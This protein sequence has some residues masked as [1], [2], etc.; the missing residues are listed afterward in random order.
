M[1]SA[2]SWIS[3]LLLCL[4]SGAVAS[5]TNGVLGIN[6][7]C[8]VQTGCFPG[9]APGFPVTI[10]GT[11]GRSYRLTSDL[12]FGG[13]D[14]TGIEIAASHTTI[15]MAGFRIVCSGFIPPST[16]TTCAATGSGTG[17][18]IKADDPALRTGL[19]VHGGH[20]L[21]MP[22]IG[23]RLGDDCKVNGVDITDGGATGTICNKNGKISDSSASRNAGAG[24][25]L[26]EGAFVSGSTASENGAHGISAG[27][28]SRV[29]DNVTN[30]NTGFG[31]ICGRGSVVSGNASYENVGFGIQGGEG[32]TVT[33]NSTYGNGGGGI[34][35]SFG[36]NVHGN[37]A[38][39][40]GSV[41]IGISQDGGYGGNVV[42]G[43]SGT[44]S[45][46]GVAFDGNACNGST[47]CP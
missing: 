29:K 28:G 42:S 20:I 3:G 39:A 41:G 6:Q 46:S 14:T 35:A 36:S 25:V 43:N 34:T 10:T 13:F 4:L 17:S 30:G 32:S 45:S 21:G 40:N 23:V 37:T 38:R 7:T 16:V 2:I 18:G 24:F 19:E 44:I 22:G 9:D 27:G 5:A 1:R 47:T 12:G 11:A 8:A 26:G 31:M 15:D 33:G